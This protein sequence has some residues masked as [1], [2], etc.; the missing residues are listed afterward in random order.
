MIKEIFKEDLGYGA[1]R[2]CRVCGRPGQTCFEAA[3]VRPQAG[4]EA[5]GLDNG[6]QPS[7]VLQTH[8]GSPLS[9]SQGQSSAE[10]TLE[11]ADNQRAHLPFVHIGKA[12]LQ[13]DPSGTDE[14]WHLFPR[15]L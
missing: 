11:V 12:L 4:P 8:M 9:G 3:R 1:C 10:V 7:V 2:D 14:V 5:E 6:S 13:E 15:D